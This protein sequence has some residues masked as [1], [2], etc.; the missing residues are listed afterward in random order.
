M[1]LI[2]NADDF[3]Y[4]PE[5][6]RATIECFEQGGLTSATIMANMPATVA[7]IE[8]ARRHPEFSFGVHLTYGSNGIER[9]L[10]RPGQIP[11]LIADDDVF[12]HSGHVRRRALMRRI[13]VDEIERE[14]AAQIALVRDSGVGVSH[15][16]SH[17]HLHKFAP[18][19]AALARVLPRFGIQRVR[20]VQDTYVKRPLGSPTFWLGGFWR[21]HL[22]RQFRTTTH[23]FMPASTA[24]TD[25]IQP[26]L[27]RE[28]DGTMEVG[29]HPGYAED[30][31]L[32][33]KTMI[34]QF[35]VQAREAG[36]RLVSWHDI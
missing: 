28:W 25:W 8:F 33:E 16:D 12:H 23:F 20:N 32:W 24:D 26:L 34:Q 6:T 13:P 1:R 9:P 27:G 10:C 18:F 2:L 3:G 35:A 5:T 36:H 15:V 31:R 11:S 21:S 29:V 4:S 7:A 14:T 30:W 19:R 22:M 17:G